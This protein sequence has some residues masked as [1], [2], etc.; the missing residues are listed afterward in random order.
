MLYRLHSASRGVVAQAAVGRTVEG[1]LLYHDSSEVEKC[2][3]SAILGW[4]EC[5]LPDKRLECLWMCFQTVDAFG[6]CVEVDIVE[7]LGV[8]IVQVCEVRMR[9]AQSLSFFEPYLLSGDVLCDDCE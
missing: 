1:A 8:D 4:Y 5:Y 2:Y 6:C 7:E 9:K 3:I